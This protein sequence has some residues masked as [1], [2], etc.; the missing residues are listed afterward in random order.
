MGRPR[1]ALNVTPA[2]TR[3]I[4]ELFV[5]GVRIAEIVRQIRRSLSTVE[6]AVRGLKRP[7][8]HPP[9]R[10]AKR[11]ARIVEL[12]TK[13]K[14]TMAELAVR[15]GL[16]RVRI[17]RIVRLGLGLIPKPKT[18]SASVVTSRLAPERPSEPRALSRLQLARRNRLIATLAGEGVVLARIATRFGITKQRAH[19]IVEGSLKRERQRAARAARNRE[20]VRLASAGIGPIAIGRKFGLTVHRVQA[21]LRLART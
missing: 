12:F 13:H 20:I 11:D 21:I 3:R 18:K 2:E 7:R 6:R 8:P 1:H 19:Q 5:A 10:N 17:S 16:P 9:A 4:R 15:F 14:C